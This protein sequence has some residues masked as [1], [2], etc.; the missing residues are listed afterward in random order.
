MAEIRIPKRPPKLKQKQEVPLP[1]ERPFAVLPARIAYDRTVSDGAIRTLVAL[2]HHC[3]RAGL[4]WISQTKLASKL[5]ITR[6]TLTMSVSRLRRAGYIEVIKK[7][8]KGHHNNTLRVIYDKDISAEEAQ[9]I[10]SNMEDCR[11]PDQL[12]EANMTPEEQ[13]QKIARM[14]QSVIKP[15]GSTAQPAQPYRMPADGETI[16]TKRIKAGMKRKLSTGYPQDEDELSTQI[17]IKKTLGRFSI[18]IGKEEEGYL[19]VL[20]E[21]K[22]KDVRARLIEQA[23]ERFLAE[24]LPP[25]KLPVL[26]DTVSDLFAEYLLNAPG[27]ST[28]HDRGQG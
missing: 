10:A 15:M 19:K 28:A 24:G 16:A 26:V 22:P 11:T 5:G 7:S 18:G 4:T 23:V 9:S 2:T 1:P 8:F 25:P 14:L 21:I 27:S 6:T 3:N 12:N 17:D 20:E 13:K